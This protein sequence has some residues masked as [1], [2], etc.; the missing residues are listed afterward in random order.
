MDNL[1]PEQRRKNM[2]AV[3]ASGTKNEV[4]LAKKLWALGL[5]YRKNDRRVVGK[6]DISFYRLKIAVFVDGEFWHGKDWE[7][8]KHDLKSNQ[9]FWFK[10]IERNMARDIEVNEALLK[11]GWKVLRFWD[12]E[13]TRDL[14]NCTDQILLSV[15]ERKRENKH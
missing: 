15:N 14:Q 10:K 8:R 4:M 9:N 2:Q 6:P 5:R 1:T 13:I 7:N 11:S 12:R 3:R